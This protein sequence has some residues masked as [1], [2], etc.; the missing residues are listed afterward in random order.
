MSPKKYWLTAVNA[1]GENSRRKNG[2]P[3]TDMSIS[4]CPSIRPRRPFSACARAASTMRAR[5]VYLKTTARIPTISSP[6]ANSAATNCHP[7]STSR[8]P[9]R[10]SLPRVRTI[11]SLETTVCTIAEM[12]NPSASGQRTSQNMKKAICRA[13]PMAWKNKALRLHEPLNRVVE[14]LDFGVAIAG[15]DGLSDAVLGVVGQKKEGN[16]FE[17]GLH[18]AHLRQDVDAVPVVPDHLL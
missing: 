15:A 14:F 18:C 16:A 10:S 2:P 12:T 1:R 4:P 11:A 17:R 7:S 9:R 3:V 8:T 6:P 5:R 13:W